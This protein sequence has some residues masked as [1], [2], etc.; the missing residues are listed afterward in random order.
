MKL[1]FDAIRCHAPSGKVGN[2]YTPLRKLPMERMEH[3]GTNGVNGANGANDT[4]G[5][6][7]RTSGEPSGD[8][9]S[10]RSI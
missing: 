5:E 1:L 8:N 4:N 10:N 7:N 6:P 3:N 9:G 2:G